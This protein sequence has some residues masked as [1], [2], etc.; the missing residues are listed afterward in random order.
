MSCG[1]LTAQGT[2]C[3]RPARAGR[4][5]HAHSGAGVGR[6]DRLS[7]EVE[8]R[9]VAELRQLFPDLQAARLLRAKVVTEHA[10]TFSAVPGVDR[11]RPAQASPLENLLLAGDWTAT[12]WP[13]TMEGAVRSGYLAAEGILADLGRP[14]R[15]IQPELK[16]GRLA[17]LLLGPDGGESS[18]PRLRSPVPG[19]TPILR[20]QPPSMPLKGDPGSPF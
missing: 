19:P 7:E 3:R 13:A 16:A 20:P 12:G 6:P 5:C 18:P 17:R 1:A 8:R 10:A 15:L 14:A 2:P 9:V 11:W 4:R